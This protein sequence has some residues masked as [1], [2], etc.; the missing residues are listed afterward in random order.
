LFGVVADGVDRLRI[1]TVLS[2]VVLAVRRVGS[3]EEA[4]D[5]S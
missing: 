2:G 5:V 4:D 1:R 3:Q